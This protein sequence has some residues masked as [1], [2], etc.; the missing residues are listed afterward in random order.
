M[1]LNKQEGGEEA[2]RFERSRWN[3]IEQEGKAEADENY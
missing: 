2:E 1:S 3:I